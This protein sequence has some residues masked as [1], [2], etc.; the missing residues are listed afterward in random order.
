MAVARVYDMV[1][2]WEMMMAALPA[3]V[4]VL[5]EVLRLDSELVG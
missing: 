2:D 3:V 1:V 5:S 4:K